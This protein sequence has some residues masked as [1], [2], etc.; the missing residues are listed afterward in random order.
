M[1]ESLNALFVKYLEDNCSEAEIETLLEYFKIPQNEELLKH[2]ILAE[3]E[4]PDELDF[5][6]PDIEERLDAIYSRVQVH[7]RAA[8]PRQK[9]V[10][11]MRWDKVAAAAAV[12]MALGAGLFFMNQGRS[13]DHLSQAIIKNNI[14]PGHNQAVLTLANGSKINLSNLVAG[15]VATQLGAS[16]TK[17]ADGQIVYQASEHISD[18]GQAIGYNTIEAPAGGQW[19]VILPDRSHVWLN[20][21]SSI[22][23]PTAFTGGERRVQLKGEAYFEVAHNAAMPFKVSSAGQ[24]VEV[25]G[26][27]FDIMAYDDEPLIKTTLLEGAVKVSKGDKV[28]MLQPGQ[29]AQVAGSEIKM[30][31]DVD[32]EDVVAW[33]NGYFKFNENLEAIMSKIARWYNVSIV[34]QSKP[35]PGYTFAGEISRERN[36]SE[37]LKIME[38]TGKVHFAVEG[39]RIIV[40]K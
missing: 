34:Y 40:N 31:D 35:N 1:K 30:T 6:I 33:K 3:L 17:T 37:I 16:I 5:P 38:Y 14:K 4:R 21:L 36:L 18:K 12:L 20:A 26:T 27:H 9:K 8:S 22:T 15:Q 2:F 24:T 11:K 39:R 29:Q 7:A 19:Q 23:Y 10:I 28:Q 13:V 25:L 32:L